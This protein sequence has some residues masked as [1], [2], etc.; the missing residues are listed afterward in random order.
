MMKRSMIM[1][2]S[3]SVMRRKVRLSEV[4]GK[5]ISWTA[6]HEYDEY[7]EY[8]YDEY[9]PYDEY[10]EYEYEYG[11]GYDETECQID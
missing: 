9:D 11:Y 7:N 3:M 2:R 10:E 1:S 6:T 4:G 8:E 5:C